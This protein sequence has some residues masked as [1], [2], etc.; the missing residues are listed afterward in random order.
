MDSVTVQGVDVPALGLGTWRLTGEQCY[1]TVSAALQ[2]GYR[3]VDTAQAY[4]NER[5]VGDAL[6]DSEVAREEVFLTTKLDWGNRR[7]DDVRRS[8][9]ASLAR[10]GTDHVDLLLIHQP[11]PTVPLAETLD[12][13]NDLVAAGKVDHVGVS[14]FDVDRLHRAREL[15]DAPVLTNQVQFSPY[16]LQTELLDYCDIHDVMLTAYSPLAH[17][18]LVDDPVLAEV[19]RR[20]D[21]TAAQVALR[22]VLQHPNVATVP[23]ATSREHLEANLDVFDFELTPAEMR[24]VRRPNKGKA[25]WGMVRGSLPV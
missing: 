20:Y 18:G 3:H 13:M 14:N 15:S 8:V 21:K 2:A 11:H 5:Q 1:A 4:G 23:K 22:W 16:W 25:L 6:G 7:Y 9:E 17:G 10:L 19:G 12:A 24:R